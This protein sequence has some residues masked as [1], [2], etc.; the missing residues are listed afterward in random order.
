MRSRVAGTALTA[1]TVIAAAGCVTAV[2]G[3]STP[4]TSLA[5]LVTTG[6]ASATTD[7]ATADTASPATVEPAP[8]TSVPTSTTGAPAATSSTVAF[9]PV[10]YDALG[11]AGVALN[12]DN[13]AVSISVWRDG[14]RDFSFTGGLR[15]D[16]RAVGSDT[17]FVIA[18]VS[19]LVTAL[20]IARL[21]QEGRIG[22]FDPVPWND[23]GV[24]HDAAW[25]GTT[26]RQLLAHT[27]GMPEVRKTWLDDPGS[28]TIPLQQAMAAPPTTTRDRWKYS[29]GNYCALGLLVEHITGLDLDEAAYDL[30][31][32]PAGITGPYLS[33]DGLDAESVPYAKGLARLQ[34]LG[35]AG[36]WLAS[37]DD[38][39]AMLAAVTDDDR[40]TLE[41]PGIIVDQYGWGHTGSLDGAEACAWLLQD[42][43]TVI[44]AFVSGSKPNTG[45][46]VCDLVVPALAA[47]LGIYAGEPVRNPD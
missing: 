44:T 16:G 13:L 11:M 37:T 36:T 7:A 43:R 32:A 9:P 27:S 19:K 23:M 3:A 42:S 47:D 21:V 22:L 15:S 18:S 39:A 4:R 40:V 34:R 10:S 41:W 24:P 30:V 2:D 17:P 38:I 31:F 46:K 33:V 45:G 25:D 28:C 6:D 35:G 14:R 29:N 1:L 12:Q 20:S 26:V 5:P 8:T